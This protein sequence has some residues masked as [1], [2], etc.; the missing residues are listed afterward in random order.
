VDTPSLRKLF[1]FNADVLLKNLNGV[2]HAQTL[3]QPVAEGN[4]LGWVLA[5]MI[6]ARDMALASLGEPPVLDPRLAA[7]FGRGS[8]PLTDPAEA[9]PLDDLR[10]AFHR[11]QQ[12]L[13]QALGR[14]SDSSDVFATPHPTFGSVGNMLELLVFHD[15]YHGGQAGLLRR[16][17][18]HANAIG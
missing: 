4:C 13:D 16:I 14:A 7:R 11:S 15:C 3:V 10:G 2:E 8:A 18:G 12:A 5:H 1:A 17:A 9:I 6:C